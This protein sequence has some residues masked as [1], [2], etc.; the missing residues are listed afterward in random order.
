ME[1]SDAHLLH[2]FIIYVGDMVARVVAVGHLLAVGVDDVLH[3]P[4]VVR[5]V[6]RRGGLRGIVAVEVRGESPCLF[7]DLA[8]PSVLVFQS[9]RSVGHGTDFPSRAVGRV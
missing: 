7:D 5:A 4:E 9:S 3:A 1:N 6:L 8:E 2:V